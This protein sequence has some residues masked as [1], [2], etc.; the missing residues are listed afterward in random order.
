MKLTKSKFRR[1]IDCKNEFWLDHH[2]PEEGQVAES[3]EYQ[4]RREAGYEVERLAR[5]LPILGD[6]D[7]TRVVFGMDFE[8]EDLFAKADIVVTDQSTGEIEIYE[9]KSGTKAKPE[10]VLDLAFQCHVATA[11]GFRVRR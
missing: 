3:L 10:Y 4:L 8:T 7:G 2:F 6:T 5:T 11:A 9:V 1:F